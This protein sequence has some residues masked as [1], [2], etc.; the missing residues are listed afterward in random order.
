MVYGIVSKVQTSLYFHFNI[1]VSKYE[2]PRF[3]NFINISSWNEGNRMIS[4]DLTDKFLTPNYKNS[5]LAEGIYLIY[6]N[7]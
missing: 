7:I 3:R 2:I 5:F 6:I 4:I 1:H